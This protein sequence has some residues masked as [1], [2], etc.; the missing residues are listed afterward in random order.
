MI[1]R[2]INPLTPTVAIWVWL[3]SILCQSM[4]SRTSCVIFDI[5]AFRCSGLSARVL[6]C[7]KLQMM[8]G[9]TRSGTRCYCCTH[10]ATVGV[11]GLISCVSSKVLML[12][13][14]MTVCR[15]DQPADCWCWR[16][17][18]VDAACCRVLSR[19]KSVTCAPDCC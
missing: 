16:S 6:G 17:R 12:T 14:L 5:W 10:M 2:V 18:P 4:L 9:L 19:N 15:C 3:S 7:Q 1:R 13:V 8:Y 11:K